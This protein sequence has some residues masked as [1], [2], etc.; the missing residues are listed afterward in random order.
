MLPLATSI[1]M[2]LSSSCCC[3]WIAFP[4]GPTGKEGVTHC[5]K[6]TQLGMD[7][8][9]TSVYLCVHHGRHEFELSN[10]EDSPLASNCED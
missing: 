2:K 4:D 10:L 5:I 3:A 7:V 1:S 6:Q 8:V 9:S